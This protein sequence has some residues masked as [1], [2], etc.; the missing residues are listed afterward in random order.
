MCPVVFGRELTALS[1]APMAPTPCLGAPLGSSQS[2]ADMSEMAERQ[3]RVE[4]SQGSWKEASTEGCWGNRAHHRG[5]FWFQAEP[6]QLGC[7]QGTLLGPEYSCWKPQVSSLH[8]SAVQ[9][10]ELG[11]SGT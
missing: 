11:D 4:T 9:G 5:T 7:A 6:L 8:G 1:T 2:A 10:I 3:Q